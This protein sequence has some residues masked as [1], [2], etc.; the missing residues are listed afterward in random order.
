MS[1]AEI[2]EKSR[3][4]I[5][6]LNA[7]DPYMKWLDIEFVE[8][9]ENYIKTKLPVRDEFLN[10]FGGI[11]GGILYSLA[12]ITAGTLSCAQ[13][14]ITPTVDGHLNYL[15][16]AI[17]KEYVTCEARLKR[18]GKHLAYFGVEIKNEEGKLLDDG[19]FTFF[20][21]ESPITG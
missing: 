2:F 1:K 9:N 8:C 11:H 17:V 20:R 18:C 12:D 10:N 7:R 4:G 19:C 6:K 21:T 16:P 15:E 3:D 14:T 13:G 5:L